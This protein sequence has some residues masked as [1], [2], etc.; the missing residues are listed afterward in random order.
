MGYLAAKDTGFIS[1]QTINNLI[2]GITSS[3]KGAINPD[4]NNGILN[5][6]TFSLTY[7][8]GKV[9]KTDPNIAGNITRISQ[10]SSTSVP[11]ELTCMISGNPANY[12]AEINKYF[13]TW[14]RNKSIIMLFYMPNDSSVTLSYGQEPDFYYSELRNLYDVLWDSNIGSSTYGS[15][16]YGSSRYYT[17]YDHNSVHYDA[18]AIPIVIN[19]IQVK[20]DA[21][22]SGR[23]VS[24]SA[25][26]VENE[27]VK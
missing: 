15:N 21:G 17:G 10:G 4:N 16:T 13:L 24:I 26:I 20:E 12:L 11:I 8:G 25:T 3:T 14:S 27:A 6:H 2:E 1:I 18:C 7:S 9:I 22:K 5:L 19:H 23:Q